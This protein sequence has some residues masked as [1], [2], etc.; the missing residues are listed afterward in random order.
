M[1]VVIFALHRPVF[2]TLSILLNQKKGNFCLS[3]NFKFEKFRGPF[4]KRLE[5]LFIFL[6]SNIMAYFFDGII[7][8]YCTSFVLLSLRRNKCCVHL[9]IQQYCCHCNH[10]SDRLHVNSIQHAMR[11]IFTENLD[12]KKF[13]KSY[14]E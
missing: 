4:F 1:V 13:F 6:F 7:D 2:P 5:T 3:K 8:Y 9:F 12:E 11:N 10:M 14:S